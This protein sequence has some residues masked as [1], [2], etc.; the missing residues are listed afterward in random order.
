MISSATIQEELEKIDVEE[1]GIVPDR[2]VELASDP[3][4][5]LHQCFEWDDGEAAHKYRLWQARQLIKRVVIQT[6]AG[7]TTPKYVSV[8]VNYDERHRKYEPIERVVRDQDKFDFAINQCLTKVKDLA[9][10]IEALNEYADNNA[11]RVVHIAEMKRTC[12][13]LE[14]L[15]ATSIH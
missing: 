2:V 11:A 13:E 7:S 10:T 4:H 14:N 12:D 3:T 8:K 6:P 9:Q 5:P 1:N 15:A